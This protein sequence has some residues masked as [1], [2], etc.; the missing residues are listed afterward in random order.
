MYGWKRTLSEAMRL[1]NKSLTAKG[2]LLL[3]ELSVRET[4][5][6]S[7]ITKATTTALC[8]MSELDGKTLLLRMAHP[9]A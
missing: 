6:T 7:Q 3:Y 1:F 2:G 8:Y 5:K 9:H 4:P